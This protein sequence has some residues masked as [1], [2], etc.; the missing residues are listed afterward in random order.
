MTTPAF[1][2]GCAMIGRR[3]ES[4][5]EHLSRPHELLA[6]YD[7]LGISAGLVYHADM[8]GT[9][10]LGPDPHHANRRLLT[11]I[12]SRPRLVPQWVLVP[13]GD[14]RMGRADE[15]VDEMLA[16]GVRAAR[17]AHLAGQPP[18]TDD[19]WAP[20][21]RQLQRR[22]VPLFADT[23]HMSVEAASSLCARY[24]EL[25][26]ILCG[27]PW[28]SDR[29]LL[30]AL[31]AC[32]NLHVE[33]HA[34]Y[35]HRALER[36]AAEFGAQ[37]LIF[38]TGLPEWDAGAAIMMPLYE[39]LSDDDRDAVAGG[40]LLRML[41]DV[42][43][44][45]T[46]PNLRP[47]THREGD[48]AIVASLRRGRPLTDEFVFDVHGHIGHDGSMGNAEWCVP[49]TDADELVRTMDRLGMNGS[50]VSSWAGLMTGDP[51]S[52]EITLRAV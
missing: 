18:L 45:G 38:G 5:P 41:Q 17:V 27:V 44:Q 9:D 36:I 37:R 15:T 49:L 2:D 19:V 33:T 48:D 13:S 8:L 32:A 26:V 30:P 46:L 34:F 47:K 12:E 25:R 52:N 35:G 39:N 28:G 40:N 22:R 23:G 7:Y 43:A 4:R 6:E 16:S 1:F 21:L 29:R 3:P 50:I 42:D 31:E 51:A 24:P 10:A 20:L 11:E 14:G